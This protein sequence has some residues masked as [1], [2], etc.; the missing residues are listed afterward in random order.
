MTPWSTA[1]CQ[2]LNLAVLIVAL[3]IGVPALPA[4][5]V[6]TAAFTPLWLAAHQPPVG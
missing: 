3:A 6:F 2:V 4:F 5:A 1:R